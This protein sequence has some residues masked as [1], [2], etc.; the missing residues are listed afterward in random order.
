MK[1]TDF[2]LGGRQLFG[3]LMPGTIWLFCLL[4]PAWDKHPSLLWRDAGAIDVILFLSVA[5]AVGTAVESLSFKVA[6]LVSARLCGERV[7]REKHD[8]DFFPLS[9]P[10]S[11]IKKARDLAEKYEATSGYVSSLSNREFSQYCK[12]VVRNRSDQYRLRLDEYEAEIN[13]MAQ[14]R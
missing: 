1:L 13:L 10:G 4:F 14:K 2:F 6:I 9:L 5:L 3:F 7:S 8:T 11:L 12:Q